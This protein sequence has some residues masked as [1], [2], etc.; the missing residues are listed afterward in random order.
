MSMDRIDFSLICFGVQILDYVKYDWL[1]FLC[2]FTI[3]SGL[4]CAVLS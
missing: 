3:I 2:H 4:S 1:T